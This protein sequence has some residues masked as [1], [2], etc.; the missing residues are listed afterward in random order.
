MKK[1]LVLGATSYIASFYI[2]EIC[3]ENKVIGLSMDDKKMSFDTDEKEL[4]LIS[5]FDYSTISIKGILEQYK[6]DQIIN[7]I[8]VKNA[9][10][11][12]KDQFDFFYQA[13]CG[14]TARLFEA[15]HEIADYH[16][17]IML[18]GSAS[19]YGVSKPAGFYSEDSPCLPDSFYGLTKI[20]QTK[21][22]LFYSRNFNDKIYIFRPSTVLGPNAP[23]GLF[24]SDIV[25]K[26]KKG[27]SK[28]SVYNLSSTRD[29][30]GIDDLITAI[31][32]ISSSECKGGIY[33]IS[34]GKGSTLAE[35][36]GLIKNYFWERLRKKIEFIETDP[37]DNSKIN[38]SILDNSKLK[39]STAFMPESD[40]KRIIYSAL[41]VDFDKR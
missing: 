21:V 22:G 18:M 39:E 27:E 32:K 12:I 8:G 20:M 3:R 26:L 7:F 10:N 25:T 15:I 34:S 35:V 9:P 30:V 33:N 37:L 17:K 29:Y 24:F 19:E 4:T 6:P 5:N 16:P 31:V 41:E 36:A 2:K 1:I 13:N 23:T 11:I 38:S 28:I 40:L 14:I